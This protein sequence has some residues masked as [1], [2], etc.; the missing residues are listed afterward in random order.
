MKTYPKKLIVFSTLFKSKVGAIKDLLILLQKEKEV[1]EIDR[2]YQE[3][4]FFGPWGLQELGRLYKGFSKS[5]LES[6][7]LHYSRNN[8]VNGLR[9]AVMNLK[10][11]NF[12]VG[13]LSSNPQFVMDKLREKL[14][15]DFAE[16]TQLDFY[17]NIANGKLWRELDRYKKADLLKKKLEKYGL[18]KEDVILVS[19]PSIVHLP[20]IKEVGFFIGFDPT[21]DNISEVFRNLYSSG[22]NFPKRTP[23]GWKITQNIRGTRKISKG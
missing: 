20:M 10:K 14:P 16:G 17:Q 13:A 19:T 6:L 2:I 22:N 8:L 15:L 9:E 11:R 21:T 12:L 7:A 3:K 4:K 23:E 1:K 18:R 5:G